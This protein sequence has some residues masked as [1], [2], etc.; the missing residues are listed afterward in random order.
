M[1]IENILR[2]NI[3][4]YLLDQYSV[5]SLLK[6][7]I[8]TFDNGFGIIFSFWSKNLIISLG[9]PGVPSKHISSFSQL[10]INITSSE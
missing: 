1:K 8:V 3:E 9:V 4:E 7:F 2:E 5:S 10:K 6:A